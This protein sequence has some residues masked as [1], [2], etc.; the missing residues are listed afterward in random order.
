MLYLLCAHLSNVIELC[1]CSSVGIFLFCSIASSDF[2]VVV[3]N[4]INIS[5]CE[6]SFV[7]ETSQ[8]ATQ[9]VKIMRSKSNGWILDER[10]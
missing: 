2:V 10:D 8:V 3:V 4:N 5:A 9:V 6:Q 7:I 1:V